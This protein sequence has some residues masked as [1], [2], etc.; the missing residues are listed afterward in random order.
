MDKARVK[1]LKKNIFERVGFLYGI[2]HAQMIAYFGEQ[3]RFLA[4]ICEYPVE[5]RQVINLENR[6]GINLKLQVNFHLDSTLSVDS[7]PARCLMN[8]NLNHQSEYIKLKFFRSIFRVTRSFP[9]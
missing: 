2:L 5:N 8:Y 3:N 6:E 4:S 1:N 7:K 9:A